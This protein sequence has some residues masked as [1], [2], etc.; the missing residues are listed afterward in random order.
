MLDR[1]EAV[2][3]RRLPRLVRREVAE[4]VQVPDAGAVGVDGG[5]VGPG[6]L[7]RAM[8]REA[9]MRAKAGDAEGQREGGEG[10]VEEDDEEERESEDS[11]VALRPS[12]ASDLG[13]PRIKEQPRRRE[14]SQSVRINSNMI[15]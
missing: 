12:R 1:G 2:A 10:E 4:G 15:N 13:S 8:P 6:R 14:G 9:C 7:R 3:P 11:P 5:L